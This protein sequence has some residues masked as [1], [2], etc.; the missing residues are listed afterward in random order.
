[1]GECVSTYN[2]IQ[3]SAVQN[4]GVV[5]PP[6]QLKLKN[7]ERFLSKVEKHP[8][9]RK[10]FIGI[11]PIRRKYLARH[12]RNVLNYSF[13]FDGIYPWRELFNIHRGMAITK[14]EMTTFNELFL[15][16]CFHKKLPVFSVERRVIERI[17]NLIVDEEAISVVQMMCYSSTDRLKK[18]LMLYQ[19]FEEIAP[20][21]VYQILVQLMVLVLKGGSHKEFTEYARSHEHLNITGEEFDEFTKLYLQ[22]YHSNVEYVEK[23]KPVFQ[24]L[25]SYMVMDKTKHT[26]KPT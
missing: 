4:N 14:L 20:C 16:E 23:S 15:K 13:K 8:L 1:M 22:I 6:S 12:I 2:E 10:R 9:L 18:N 3:K 11:D 26:L 5:A 17:G 7:L 19:K 25:R 21:Q 24:K